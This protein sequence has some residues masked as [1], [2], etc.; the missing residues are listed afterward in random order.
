M[1]SKAYGL[2]FYDN[3]I[4]KRFEYCINI[5]WLIDGLISACKRRRYWDRLIVERLYFNAEDKLVK[6]KTIHTFIR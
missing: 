3:G 5:L 2:Y 4:Y 6:H 1:K